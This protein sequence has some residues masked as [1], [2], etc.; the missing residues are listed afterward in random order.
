MAQERI[1]DWMQVA[2]DLARA[3]RELQIEHWVYIT[4]EYREDDRS[5]VVLRKIDIP[6]RMLDRW[7]WL[8]EWRKAALVCRYP[9]K[10]VQVYY[11]YY[12]KR[13]GLQTGF[14]SLL[15]RV[16]AAQAQITKTERRI[17][18]YVDYMTRNDLFFDPATD[19]RLRCAKEKLAQ[20]RAN[21][22][23]LYALLQKE[24]EKHQANPGIYKLFV[25]FDKL[26]EFGSAQGARSHAENCGRSGTFN[27]IG[28]R[29]RDSW[30][31]SEKA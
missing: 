9:R 6:R 2:K 14:G 27:I 21:Y 7:Q 8:V 30:Y 26:G 16:A 24:V 28:D 22:A 10:G 5:R 1:D 19:E 11:C 18:E 31:Q 29:Y 12:D 13:T 23:D 15:S 3:E 17:T 25:G 4:F 20:K